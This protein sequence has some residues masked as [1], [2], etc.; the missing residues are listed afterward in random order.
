MILFKS[1]P[2]C[3]GDRYVERDLFGSYVTC[4]ACGSVEYPEEPLLRT[5]TPAPTA[6][7][8]VLADGPA[9]QLI[10]RYPLALKPSASRTP[11]ADR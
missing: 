9:A 8:N 7:R 2:R 3:G 1:C 5:Y 11:Q 10:A 6:Q 4:L